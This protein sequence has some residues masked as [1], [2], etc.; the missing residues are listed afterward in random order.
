MWKNDEKCQNFKKSY[1]FK[2][3]F[4]YEQFCLFWLTETYNP[5]CAIVYSKRIFILYHHLT[6]LFKRIFTLW[7]LFLSNL[8]GILEFVKFIIDLLL[9]ISTILITKYFLFLPNLTSK[10]LL[11]LPNSTVLLHTVTLTL[12]WVHKVLNC[13]LCQSQ[14][15]TNHQLFNQRNFITSLLRPVF[16]FFL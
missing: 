4:M 14:S 5:Q 3:K 10:S 8:I 9:S 7:H 6:L 12:G 15:T 16:T 2:K 13:K 11:V 1:T